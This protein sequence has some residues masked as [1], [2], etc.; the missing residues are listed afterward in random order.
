MHQAA[1]LAVKRGAQRIILC[2]RRPLVS[3]HYDIPLEFMDRRMNSKTGNKWKE[4]HFL[5]GPERAEYIKRMRGGGMSALVGIFCFLIGLFLG[6][7]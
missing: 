2:S 3:R 5:A 1:L 6:L 7:F 4:W